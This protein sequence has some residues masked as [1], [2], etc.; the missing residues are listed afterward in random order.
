LF[1]NALEEA[2]V[3]VGI[4]V[5]VKVTPQ[6]WQWQEIAGQ[7][8]SRNPWGKRLFNGQLAM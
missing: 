5:E 1:S 7:E 8:K 4:R 3:I 6:Q 2:S